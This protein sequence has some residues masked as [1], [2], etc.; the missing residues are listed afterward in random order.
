MARPVLWESVKGV[1]QACFDFWIRHL[2]ERGTT[3]TKKIMV[4]E[5][6]DVV[7]PRQ[8]AR[9]WLVLRRSCCPSDE[10]VLE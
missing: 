6:R 3:P 2:K 9:D 1:H 4:R 7:S 10:G 8:A 5:L